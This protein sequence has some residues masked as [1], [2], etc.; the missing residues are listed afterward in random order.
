MSDCGAESGFPFL[1]PSICLVL[2]PELLNSTVGSDVLSLHI[3]WIFF[4]TFTSR[5]TTGSFSPYFM[6]LLYEFSFPKGTHPNLFP[7]TWLGICFLIFYFGEEEK[8]Y[9]L[10]RNMESGKQNLLKN[11][12]Y[13][14]FL[15]IS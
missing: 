7:L 5:S 11:I 6:A 1:D 2:D 13:R 10:I 14:M 8:A 12:S 3:S 4:S 15:V 9:I